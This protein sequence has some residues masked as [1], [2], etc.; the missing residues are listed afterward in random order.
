MITFPNIKINLGL[1]V[2]HKRE[3]GFHTIESVFYPI[4]FCD[5][6][7]VIEKN[8]IPNKIELLTEGLRIAGNVHANLIVKAY[9]LLDSMYQLPPVQVCLYKK[10]PMGAGLGGGSSNGAFMLTLLN[11]KFN[12]NISHQTLKTLAAK[13]GSDCAFFID[14]E[15]AYLFGKGHELNPC[16]ISLKGKHLVLLAPPFHS[17]TQMAY[18]GVKP[19]GAFEGNLLSLLETPISQ[20]KNLIRN[21]FEHSVFENFPVLQELKNKLYQ[22][23]AV[24]ASMSGSGSAMYGIFEETPVIDESMNQMVIFNEVINK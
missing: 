6:L 2:M 16:S 10:I 4:P 8:H 18:A 19:R 9:H 5:M 7:E 17:N 12:L 15:P 20:W 21:D 22:I 11:D 3:D 24:Y 23:G 14:N 13:L 1:Q